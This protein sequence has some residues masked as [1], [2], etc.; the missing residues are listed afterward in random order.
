[1]ADFS[2]STNII[3]D[4]ERNIHYIPTPNA[5]Q[6]YERIVNNFQTGHRAFNIVGSYGTGKSSFLWALG[7]NLIGK[8]ESFFGAVNGHFQGIKN[9]QFLNQN[10]KNNILIGKHGFKKVLKG[11]NRGLCTKL[12]LKQL[13]LLNT[14]PLPVRDG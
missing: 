8:N 5:K 7:Q 12:T 2:V 9:F 4:K 11:I 13:L 10:G 6:V 14:I 3:R 1:M